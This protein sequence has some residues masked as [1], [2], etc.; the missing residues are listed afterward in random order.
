MYLRSVQQGALRP[1]EKEGCLVERSD[2]YW[3]SEAL[4]EAEQAATL[5]EVPVGCVIV[6][7][8][9]I[10]AR[11]H[12]LRETLQDPTAHAEV[13]ALRR[14]AQ[15]RGSWHLDDT[16]VYCTLEPCC[17]CAGALVNARVGGLVYALADPKSGACGSV[18]NVLQDPAL[19][20]R[21]AVRG[22]LLAEESLRIMRAF[23]EPRRQ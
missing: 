4:K 11:G 14:A 15:A 21:V 12:N 7:E 22:G 16:L 18:L 23:F 17:M 5:G 9:A 1:A 6:H 13:V 20:H 10:I 3:M 2:E 8:G 19:N